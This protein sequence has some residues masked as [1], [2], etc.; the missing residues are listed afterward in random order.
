GFG[1]ISGVLLF[2]RGARLLA[3]TDRARWIMADVTYDGD[4]LTELTNARTGLLK[5]RKGKR[6]SNSRLWDA[7]A[8]DFYGSKISDGV[9]VGFERDT[10]IERYKLKK[11]GLT[12]ASRLILVP[13]GLE[14]G[15]NNKE[16]ESVGRFTSGPHKG[17]FI[18]ISE[19]NFDKNG[20]VIAYLWRGQRKKQE[21]F[22]I[23]RQNDFQVTDIALLDD[24]DFVILE[25]KLGTF[26][27]PSMAIRYF[28]AG[29]IGAGKTAVGRVLMS[30]AAP[31]YAVDN[32]EGL[33]AHKDMQGRTIFTIVSDN[34]F[35]TSLQRTLLLQFVWQK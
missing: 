26:R 19:A 23:K 7:E 27:I 17:K 35:N 21:R 24:G 2:D 20:N 4:R 6:L 25:R 28:K 32:M 9:I 10:R 1:G 11:N 15:R 33:S 30:A 31:A 3:V 34:N 8:I 16:L 18:G 5:N 22:A 12:G 13:K 29:E 14:R